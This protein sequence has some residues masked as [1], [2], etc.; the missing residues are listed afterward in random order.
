MLPPFSER[1]SYEKR[2]SEGAHRP[3]RGS[4]KAVQI[5]NR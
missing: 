2:K 5:D 4:Q 3:E 1:E